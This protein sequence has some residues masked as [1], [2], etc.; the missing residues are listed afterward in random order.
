MCEANISIIKNP[1]WVS[2]NIFFV[3]KSSPELIFEEEISKILEPIKNDSV[4]IFY[5]IKEIQRF[6]KNKKIGKI[7]FQKFRFKLNAKNYSIKIINYA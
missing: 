6:L 4:I 1:L 7:D 2:I 3:S 5:F